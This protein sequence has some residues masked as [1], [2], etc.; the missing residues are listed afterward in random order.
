MSFSGAGAGSKVGVVAQQP[1]SA[2]EES[3]LTLLEVNSE[4]SKCKNVKELE[5][6][7]M[8]LLKKTLTPR[9]YQELLENTR[10]LNVRQ[11]SPERS[12]TALSAATGKDEDVFQPP[13]RSSTSIAAGGYEDVFRFEPEAAKP[14]KAASGTKD[15]FGRVVAKAGASASSKAD[16]D[17][18]VFALGPSRP[19]DQNHL[20]H[21]DDSQF[22]QDYEHLQVRQLSGSFGAGGRAASGAGKSAKGGQ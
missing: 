11:F 7:V 4:L 17:D 19:F 13:K 21:R 22:S 16:D 9:F 2:I 1:F 10:S 12:P 3:L 18:D 6:Q 20:H 15:V 14:K 8:E 5:V